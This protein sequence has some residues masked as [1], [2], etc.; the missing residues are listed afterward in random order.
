MIWINSFNLGRYWFVGPQQTLY[1]PGPLL[2]FSPEV[3]IIVVLE[4][5][6][7]PE[8]CSSSFVNY[9]SFNCSILLTDN[10]IIDGPTPYPE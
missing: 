7:A 3:N 9:H 8:L 6:Y 2:K 1:L 5:E 4:L 10:H